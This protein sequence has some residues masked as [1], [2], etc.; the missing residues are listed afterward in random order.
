MLPPVVAG[1][2]VTVASLFPGAAWGAVGWS[3][4]TAVV[5]AKIVPESAV[6]LGVDVG[7]AVKVRHPGVG[8]DTA[9]GDTGLKALPVHQYRASPPFRSQSV[10]ASEAKEWDVETFTSKYS[11][12]PVASVVAVGFVAYFAT[13]T[14][15]TPVAVAATPLVV[16][17]AVAVPVCVSD[18]PLE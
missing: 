3:G 8:P 12:D 11:P 16:V 13:V 4:A 17:V 9:A 1:V 7:V 18:D 10:T 5:T 6:R 14:A 15:P 2:Q